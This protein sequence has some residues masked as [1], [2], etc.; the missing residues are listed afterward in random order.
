MPGSRERLDATM[1]PCYRAVMK[2]LTIRLEDRQANLLDTVARLDNKPV[3][4]VVREALDRHISE[5]FQDPGF[6]E[7]LR[8]EAD[9]LLDELGRQA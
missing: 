2:N 3:A 4:Q 9:A 6:Q 7:R 8:R 1:P 5:R